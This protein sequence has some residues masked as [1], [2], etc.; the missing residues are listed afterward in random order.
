M[1]KVGLILAVLLVVSCKEKAS[2]EVDESAT[3]DKVSENG[4]K[5]SVGSDG[6]V[7]ANPEPPSSKEAVPSG[8]RK[9]TVG[10]RKGAGRDVDGVANSKEAPGPD[11]P[12]LLHPH[13]PRAFSL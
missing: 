11:S 13:L 8:E 9:A 1:K 10:D 2:Q 4:T 3:N 6:K 12:K 7:R 5:T